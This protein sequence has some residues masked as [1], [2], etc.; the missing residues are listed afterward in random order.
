YSWTKSLTA[1]ACFLLGALI[2]STLH[3]PF[4][5]IRRSVFV[6]SFALQAA[7]IIIAAILVTTGVVNG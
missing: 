3:R 1:I 6:G 7:L 4:G 2:F 5:P